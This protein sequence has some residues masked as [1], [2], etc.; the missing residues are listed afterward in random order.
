MVPPENDPEP[1][2]I[3]FFHDKLNLMEMKAFRKRG[4]PGLEDM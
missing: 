4:K 1:L 3:A 2:I